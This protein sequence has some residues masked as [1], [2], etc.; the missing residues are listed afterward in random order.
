MTLLKSVFVERVIKQVIELEMS[1][2]NFSTRSKALENM[3]KESP[4]FNEL[5]K[6]LD[7][8][9]TPQDSVT[10]SDSGGDVPKEN[11][12]DLT[13]KSVE[14]LIDNNLKGGRDNEKI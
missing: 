13:S 5:S 12:V 9:N 6:M 4:R 10:L 3:L 11:L 8:F 7:A 14:E 2:N 1:L